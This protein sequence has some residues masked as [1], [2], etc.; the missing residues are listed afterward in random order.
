MNVAKGNVVTLSYVGKL[1]GGSIFDQTQETPFEFTVGAGEVIAGFDDAVVGMQIGEEKT[2]T[3]TKDK[4]YGDI[5]P[6]LIKPI[7]RKALP[8]GQEPKAG[9]TLI[10]RAQEGVSMPV[11]IT[12]VTP[13][14]V[15]VDLNHPL[16]GKTLT[17]TI[18]VIAV[19]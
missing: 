13:T 18:K 11:P 10:I 9:M 1:D 3:L 2:F 12:K 6:E 19:T 8:P 4:A 16:A 15:Y 14:H 17:F 5:N 7:D